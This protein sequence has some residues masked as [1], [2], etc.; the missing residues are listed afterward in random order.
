MKLKP[1]GKKL[2]LYQN[3]A[4]L[5]VVGIPVTFHFG[6]ALLFWACIIALI[7]SISRIVGISIDANVDKSGLWGHRQGADTLIEY[8]PGD[9]DYENEYRWQTP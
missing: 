1:R 3:T 2:A 5:A 8:E 4:L 7:V 6:L 9:I